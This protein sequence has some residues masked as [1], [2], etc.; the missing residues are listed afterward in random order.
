MPTWNEDARDWMLGFMERRERREFREMAELS[1]RW[2]EVTKSIRT[3]LDQLA[4]LEVKSENQLREME[5]YRQLLIDSRRQVSLFSQDAAQIIA[6]EQAVSAKAGIQATETILRRYGAQFRQLPVQAVNNMIGRTMNGSPLY[7]LLIKDYPDTIERI[8]QQLVNSTA[9]GINPRVTA[10]LIKKDMDG[11]LMRA[12]R[13]ARTEQIHVFREASQQAMI[14]SGVV[15]GM[16]RIEQP[17]ACPE[18]A[19]ENGKVYP[20]G[21]LFE[22][23]PNCRGTWIPVV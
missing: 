4:A 21:T 10:R 18:C 8:T 22:T 6:R 16:E 11:N 20:L 23:H 5:I 13:V 2:A 1:S 3:R 15:S 17:D 7:D 9:R 12:L 19:E 14:A